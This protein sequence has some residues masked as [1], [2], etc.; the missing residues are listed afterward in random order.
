MAASSR[1]RPPSAF[2]LQ[3]KNPYVEDYTATPMAEWG[4]DLKTALY[5]FPYLPWT[6]LSA[7]P[8]QLAEQAL[9]GWY[10]QRFLYLLLFLLMLWL[11]P[12]LCAD[13]TDR[14]CLT[15][16]LGLNPI[17]ANDV[18]FGQ[19]DS[20]VLFWLVLFAYGLVRKRWTLAG[21]ALGLAVASKSTAWFIA[22][23]F[24]A[25]LWRESGR[26][27]IALRRLAPAIVVAAVLVLPFAAWNLNAMVDDIWRWSAGTIPTAYQIRGWGLSN[28]VLA[29]GGVGSRLDYFPFW[30]PELVVGLPVLAGLLWRQVKHD[31]TP[32]AMFWGYGVFTFAFLYVSRFLNENYLGFL[33]AVL[34]LGYYV[35]AAAPYQNTIASDAESTGAT[36]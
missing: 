8:F 35:H 3:G 27:G 32:A 28:A 24:L 7:I 16:I 4:T 34:A 23:F 22:P 26:L 29:L 12:K 5:H 17:M 1:Q 31:N 19:N 10:D 20:F 30:I 21:V 13:R 9:F 2:L 6:F 14:L 18:I 15:M 11:A 25:Y 36:Q 33:I